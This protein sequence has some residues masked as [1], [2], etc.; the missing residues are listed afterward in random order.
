MKFCN[1]MLG[2]TPAVPTQSVFRL[3]SKPLNLGVEVFSTV[4]LVLDTGISK[5]IL[6]IMM[7]RTVNENAACLRRICKRSDQPKMERLVNNDA[8]LI[9][10]RKLKQIL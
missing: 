6:K 10:R 8:R 5:Q 3:A 9:L 1:S 4:V 2:A 7:E